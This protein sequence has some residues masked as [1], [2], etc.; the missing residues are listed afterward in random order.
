MLV[1]A[2][3]SKLELM[4]DLEKHTASS[5]HV[6]TL[7]TNID[8]MASELASVSTKLQ[9]AAVQLSK[10]KARSKAVA[11]HTSVSNYILAALCLL[12]LDYVVFVDAF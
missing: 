7:Q 12:F 4:H 2:E 5:E 9:Q 6:K 3:Q 8:D 1:Y 11:E 10:E